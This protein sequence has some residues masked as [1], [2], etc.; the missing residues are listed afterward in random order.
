MS[1]SYNSIFRDLFK[2]I[3]CVIFLINTPI[4]FAQLSGKTDSIYSGIPWFD[5]NGNV[6]S[7]HGACII[8]E[9]DKFYLFG[10]AHSDTSNAFAGFN[11]YSS[12]DLY[13]WKL[14]RIALPVQKLGKLGTNSVGERVKVMKNPK[15]KEYVMFMHADS[16]TY[17]SQFVGY[18][19]SKTIIGP[20]Q[21][22]GALLFNGKPIKKWDM[23]T[24]Q[25]DDGSGYI[26]IH[27]GEIYKL[28]EDY[29]SV[30][31][32]INP[33]MTSGFESPTMFKKEGLYYF[34][35][36]HL[37]S[38]ER[39]DNYYYTSNSIKGPWISRGLIAPE[40]SL[41]WNSQ[42]TFVLPIVG[43]K[44]ITYMFMGDRWS[45]PKQ[46][47]SATYVWQPLLVSGTS[48][49]M[50]TYQEGWQI[51][52]ATGIASTLKTVDT[53][54][55]NTDKQIQYTGNWKHINNGNS[56]SVS[57]SDEKDSSFSIQFSGQQIALYSYVGV[58]NGYAKIVLSDKKRKVMVTS[59]IDMYGK[60]PLSTPVFRS[61]LL[62]KDDYKLTVYVTG[63]RPNWSDKRNTIYGSTGNFVSM[64]K[65]I[66]N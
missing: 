1:I 18:A 45:F 46:A 64:D 56:G 33:N 62:K 44:D 24:F 42:C 20:Y 31:E 47:S 50:P 60:S 14:E 40:G 5:Q 27:G 4:L 36:S 19:T 7:A 16:I 15:T 52:V 39:N 66:I 43:T 11:C 28:S 41:T 59:I 13:N 25:D 38:W 9:T 65:L 51:N 49:S 29:K 10:E 21:F 12:K 26:L 34:I 37:T 53:T 22:K 8:K 17:K 55:E 58:E 54:I 30:V 57:K 23:G 6:V 61:P 2:K 48:L 3:I 35:G 32:Q 63:E